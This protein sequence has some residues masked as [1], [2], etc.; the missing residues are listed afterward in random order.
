MA[1]HDGDWEN[2][3]L[4]YPEGKP[5]LATPEMIGRILRHQA[6]QFP[7]EH[8][9]LWDGENSEVFPGSARIIRD[10][11]PGENNQTF[12]RPHEATT[13]TSEQDPV[14]PRKQ[15]MCTGRKTS[16]GKNV[17]NAAHRKQMRDQPPSS[18]RAASSVVELTKVFAAMRPTE[19]R[20]AVKFSNDNGGP[21]SRVR[22]DS[23]RHGRHV[24]PACRES[25]GVD[26]CRKRHR[27]QSPRLPFVDPN[28][29]EHI[30]T[31]TT[32]L[33]CYGCNRI[34][35]LWRECPIKNT[36]DRAAQNSRRAMKHFLREC[37]DQGLED[38]V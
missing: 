29:G 6:L 13:P 35:H 30:G 24:Q 15:S 11:F 7:Y 37:E 27:A 18:D 36:P 21:L 19:V 20:I 32:Q 26:D 38:K 33:S 4:P 9:L 5:N 28:G 3:D 12:P 14:Q 10:L 16:R 1:S 22:S 23:F 2:R 17:S 34:G 31:Q 8:S 25:C